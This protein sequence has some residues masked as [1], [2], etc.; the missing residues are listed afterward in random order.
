MRIKEEFVNDSEKTKEENKD[1]K[2]VSD[3]TF[4]ILLGLER[5]ADEIARK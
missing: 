4:V 5:I 1:K 3:D 2:V